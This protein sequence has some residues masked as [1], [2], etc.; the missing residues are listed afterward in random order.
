MVK[1]STARLAAVVAAPL[2]AFTV[3]CGGSDDASGKDAEKQPENGSS[4]SPEVTEEPGAS[5]PD[6]ATLKKA[7]LADGEVKGYKGSSP[8]Q[9][10]LT[11]KADRAECQPLADLTAYGTGRSPKA[12]AFAGR[13][14]AGSGEETAG[15]IVTVSLLS[16]DGGGATETVAGVRS[17]IEACGDGF[18]TSGNNGGKTLRYTT[19]EEVE[20]PTG[21]D[22]AVAVKLVG[23][24]EG[25]E[26]PMYFT[27]VRSG[28]S[29][30]QFMNLSIKD[31]AGAPVPQNVV[32][33]Q[34]EK[35]AEATAG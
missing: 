27:V 24:A 10:A 6:E 11:P 18:A 26:V 31:P 14:F 7:L 17:A 32:T 21:G 22:E 13:G 30:A 3:A 20:T 35:L 23:E 8:E 4:A 5:A 2:L 29:L 33:A 25:T 9:E 28:A 1:R 34:M 19:V 16:Y 12:R 15:R